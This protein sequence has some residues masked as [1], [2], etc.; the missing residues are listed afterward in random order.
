[1]YIG[2]ETKAE[3]IVKHF[4]HFLPPST[5]PQLTEAIEKHVQRQIENHTMQS[6]KERLANQSKDKSKQWHIAERDMELF[7]DVVDRLPA[8]GR[9]QLMQL[10]YQDLCTLKRQREKAVFKELILLLETNLVDRYFNIPIDFPEFIEAIDKRYTKEHFL[11]LL[12]MD[13]ISVKRC[14]KILEALNEEYKILEEE[15]AEL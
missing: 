7:N 8:H 13:K 14:N 11:T 15:E 10:S 3:E 5:K 6:F 9:A 12:K 1:M 2:H 4:G